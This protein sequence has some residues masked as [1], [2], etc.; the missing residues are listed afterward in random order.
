MTG[1]PAPPR[2]PRF[3]RLLL[4][5][6]LHREDRECALSDVGEEFERRYAEHGRRAARHWYRRQAL[7]SVW[8]AMTR[9]PPGLSLATEVRW[10]W[11]GV[12]AR[13][14]RAAFIVL[15]FGVALAANAIVFAA[16]DAFVFRPVPYA[17]P[18][19]LAIV[20]N[21]RRTP[22]EFIPPAAFR[23]W[24]QHHD[25]FAA[26]QAHSGGWGAYLTT[27]GTTE[28]V[29]GEQVTPGMFELLGVL[30]KWGRPF[31]NADTVPGA[32]PVAIIGE[33]LARRLFVKPADAP[34]R[35][36]FTGRDTLTVVGVMPASFRFPTAREEIW[37]PLDLSTWREYSGIKDIVRLAPGQTLQTAARAVADQS[38]TVERLAQ[39]DPTE[40][41]QLRSM[42]DV[43]GNAGAATVFAI[44]VGAAACLLLIAC[45]N[46]ASLEMAA[47]TVRMR[48]Y[49]IQTALGASRASLVRVG[50]LEGGMLLGTSGVVA[51]SLTWWGTQLLDRQLTAPM[52][53][54]LTNPIDVDPRVLTFMLSVAAMAWLLTAW[55]MVWRISRTS[56]VDGL[57]EDAR[58]MPV[59]RAEARS[60]H[61]LMAGQVA[62]TTLLLVG[63]LLFLR[64]YMARVGLDKGF[65][66]SNIATI[67]IDQAPDAA[68]TPADLESEIL[69]RLRATPGVRSVSRT[70]SLPPSTQSGIG[71]PLTIDGREPTTERVMLHFDDTDPEYFQTMDI[72][73]V[74][75]RAFDASTPPDQVVVD[76]R[77]ARAYWPDQS[78]LGARFKV[79][80]TSIG[81]V[82]TFQI[83]GI[84]RER[85]SDRIENEAGD[86]V[87]VVYLRLSP[88]HHPLTFVARLDDERRLGD[89]GP[90]VRSIADRSIVRVDTVSARYARLAGDTRMAASVTSGFGIIALVVATSGIYAVMAFLVA[91]RSKEIAI[92]MALGADRRSIRRLIFNSALRFVAVGALLGLATAVVTS[93]WI[94]AQLFHVT[95][96]DPST[97]AAVFVLVVGTALAATW[98]PAR[99]A[100][101]VD[102]AVTLRA[103]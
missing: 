38:A 81:G 86:E 82:D 72:R 44:L 17:Q 32:P 54:A 97:Y 9:L 15:L 37:Q 23:E 28:T 66:A 60:R 41:M 24:R 93:R 69:A 58:T 75:G 63:A 70:A 74:Q 18:D 5:V 46:V 30:P 48:V 33:A 100:A 96:T 29:S 53:D 85:R 89:L 8:P 79:G 59:T 80:S 6:V 87:Y 20:E 49:A 78:A 36:F 76:E 31:T 84:S 71:G 98:W 4:N 91:G 25:L 26:V 35:T 57:R 88:T 42:A 99:R 94:A 68:R 50:L 40:H 43:R 90:I 55:P 19:R 16:A 7:T 21:V 92:R 77:F 73:I 10:A 1:D 34:G 13:G 12:R 51:V 67:A 45:A 56:I 102:P 61:V 47:A 11:R 83:A 101:Q 103:Q 52:R 2:P 14:W 62:L 64:T 39:R 27:G 95:P 65:D 3:A 22:S